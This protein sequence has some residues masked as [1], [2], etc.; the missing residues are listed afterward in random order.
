M[1]LFSKK[2]N[3]GAEIIVE[4]EVIAGLQ[5]ELKNQGKDV[6]RVEIAGFG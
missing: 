2:S 4:P 5:E 3:S 1:G 6:A